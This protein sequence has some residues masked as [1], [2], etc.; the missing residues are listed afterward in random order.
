MK[1]PT[2]QWILEKPFFSFFLLL[3]FFLWYSLSIIPCYHFGMFYVSIAE[4]IHVTSIYMLLQRIFY[5]N[6]YNVLRHLFANTM[7]K[8]KFYRFNTTR[9]HIVL[10]KT[11][12]SIPR[13]SS[14]YYHCCLCLAC[15]LILAY[16]YTTFKYLTQLW[17]KIHT[18]DVPF[19]SL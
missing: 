19:Y 6:L 12:I 18:S 8:S 15:W 16:I 9:M 5:T 2:P 4:K 1:P 17:Y 11:H 3:L 14:E 7:R 10:F 13:S